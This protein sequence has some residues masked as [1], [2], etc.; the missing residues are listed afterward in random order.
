MTFQAILFD[1]DGTL[2]QSLPAVDR[3]WESWALRVGLDPVELLPQIHGRR[4]IDSLAMFLPEGRDL[5]EEVA[6]LRQREVEDTEGITPI[7]GARLLVDNLP[8]DR[9]GIVT[10]GTRDV[11]TARIRAGG[12]RIP[13]VFVAGEDVA[14]GK[15]AKDPFGLG[16]Q[17]GR[18]DPAKVLAFEDT[19]AGMQSARR[20]GCFAVQIGVDIEDL[21]CIRA[22]REPDG[23]KILGL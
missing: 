16:C 18:W 20:A 15:P 8:M 5:A 9:W 4:A 11:A 12:F 23:L 7:P 6:W 19:D 1:L 14:N 10:S 2:V 3:A 13:L 22:L 21:S 17:R